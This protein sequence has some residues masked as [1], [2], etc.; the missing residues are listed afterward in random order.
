MRRTFLLVFL[1]AGAVFGFAS[2]ARAWH[3]QGHDGWG[4]P[5]SRRPSVDTLAEACVRAARAERA[6]TAPAT[7]PAQ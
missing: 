7:P 1:A 6:N 2:A 5:W 4:G 3:Y